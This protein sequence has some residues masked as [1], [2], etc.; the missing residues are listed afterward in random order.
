MI[1]FKALSALLLYPSDELIAALPEIIQAIAAE[2]VVTEAQ[3]DGLR[4]LSETLR[5]GDLIE[6][7]ERYVEIFD[8]GRATSLHLFEHV[9]S[10]SR[11][12]G[13]AMVDLRAVYR[14]A[15][16]SMKANELPDY[17][18]A[19]LEYL[20]QVPLEEARAML[21][22]CSHILSALE[23][24]LARRESP[25]AAVFAV[26]L[27]IVGE[28]AGAEPA[29]SEEPSLDEVWAEEPIL[30]GPG[31][32]P[33]NAGRPDVSVVRFAHNTSKMQGSR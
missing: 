16:F 25:Y 32:Q 14:R 19:L 4:E 28:A 9:H 5:R 20:S 24:E 27:E 22:D 15:G 30:F 6:V 23:R 12:R 3:V 18:P 11:D 13:Q 33:C 29:E 1:T 10:E 17:L 2:K 26:L 8:R 7:Q 31:A 21:E